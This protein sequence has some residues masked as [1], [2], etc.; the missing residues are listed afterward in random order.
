MLQ[1]AS[2]TARFTWLPAPPKSL[3]LRS[4]LFGAFLAPLLAAA[5]SLA[6]GQHHRAAATV[7][8]PGEIE[9]LT[10]VD[11]AVASDTSAAT[12]DLDVP[13]ARRWRSENI[14]LVAPDAWSESSRKAV[15][16]ALAT[17]PVR[18]RS[19]LGN[20]ALGPTYISVNNEGRGLSGDQPYGGAANYYS[21]NQR[22]NEVVLYPQ[23]S[24]RTT[25]H[26]LGHAYNLRHVPAGRYA[27]VFLDPEMKGFLEAA[28]WRVL[29]PPDALR[30]MSDHAAVSVEYHGARVWA[31]SGLS[32]E[33]PLEDFANSFALFFAAP[34]ELQRLS[35]ARFDWFAA[36]FAAPLD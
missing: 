20:P 32:R 11:A 29:T 30:D 23:Q 26:E 18:V 5:L 17:L 27:Q 7:R 33:D 28:G 21:T 15:D 22:R 10:T 25:L 1:L 3:G 16:E 34:Q 12:T 8:L 24:L 14:F 2:Q 36:R 6:A 13:G 4:V 31:A 35:L 9:Q 19:Q